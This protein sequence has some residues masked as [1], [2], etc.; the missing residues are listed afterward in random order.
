MHGFECQV[1]GG[2]AFES[3][4]RGD[5]LDRGSQV[6]AISE[7]LG[8]MLD[9][10]RIAV[11]GKRKKSGPYDLKIRFINTHFS[12]SFAQGK[13]FWNFHIKASHSAIFGFP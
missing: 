12:P 10:Q 1:E 7:Q 9:A 4:E 13:G 6:R 5:A 2:L 3:G 11:Q 8:G